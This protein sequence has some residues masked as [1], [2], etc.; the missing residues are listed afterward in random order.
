MGLRP[1]LTKTRNVGGCSAA[2]RRARALAT[3][4]HAVLTLAGHEEHGLA[5]AVVKAHQGHAADDV[6]HAA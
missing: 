2:G 4:P 3:P 6:E 5:L 1:Q